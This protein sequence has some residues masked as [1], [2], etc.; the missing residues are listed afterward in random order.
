VKVNFAKNEKCGK[1]KE[2]CV[3][4][5]KKRTSFQYDEEDHKFRDLGR[6]FSTARPDIYFAKKIKIKGK[7]EKPV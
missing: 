5:L 3:T 7:P 6:S 4:R 1:T 2:T